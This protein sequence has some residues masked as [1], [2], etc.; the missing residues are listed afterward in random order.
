M[1]TPQILGILAL[2]ALLACAQTPREA[3][4]REIAKNT[5]VETANSVV[6]HVATIASLK[7]ISVMS[8]A[9]GQQVY[10]SGYATPGDGGQGLFSYNT[11]S[12]AADNGGTIIAPISGTGRWLRADT[13]A[14]CRP[15]WWGGFPDASTDCASALQKA[16][17]LGPQVRLSQGTYVIGSTVSLRENR[18]MIGAGEW[19]S[20]VRFTGSGSALTF[21]PFAEGDLTLQ[22][23]NITGTNTGATYAIDATNGYHISLFRVAVIG[24]GRFTGGA[25]RIHTLKPGNAAVWSILACELMQTRGDGITIDGNGGTGGLYVAHCRI[26]GNAGKGLNITTTPGNDLICISNDIE[27]NGGGAIYADWLSGSIIGNHFE[28]GANSAIPLVLGTNGSINGLTINNNNISG[29]GV[30]QV[31]IDLKS[32]GASVG[33]NIENNTFA[34]ASVAAIR[35]SKIWGFSVRN[36]NAFTVPALLVGGNIWFTTRNML[37]QDYTSTRFMGNPTGGPP[38]V[39]VVR[40]DP[41]IIIGGTAAGSP[42]APIT[43][44]LSNTITWDP[45]NLTSGTQTTT[46]V[47]VTGAALGDIAMVS[48]SLS[49]QNLVLSAFVSAADTVTVVLR[50]DT[51]GDVHLASGTLRASVWSYT[52]RQSDAF[53][54]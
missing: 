23:L 50:N 1:K 40:F 54:W 2:C 48:Y 36:N 29:N 21:V 18:T 31:L 44:H 3:P 28:Q 12:V 8:V 7:A 5:I 14:Y 38:G 20:I 25:I 37:V 22:D 19:T 11:S 42:G 30:N 16:L 34:G 13:A 51:G 49:Q 52:Q 26:Q 6:V 15:E 10:V 4:Q 53:P 27:G 35:Y 45:P 17:N 47:T 24:G 43:A 41:G 33:V 9:N 32:A 39:S 46:T